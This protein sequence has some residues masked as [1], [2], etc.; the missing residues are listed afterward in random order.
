MLGNYPEV[1]QNYLR[2]KDIL[3]R[4]CGFLIIIAC[5][6]PNMARAVSIENCAIQENNV[7]KEGSE[8]K[9]FEFDPKVFFGNFNNYIKSINEL[10]DKN[11]V[12]DNMTLVLGEE[13]VDKF[14]ESTIDLRYCILNA[15]MT[16]LGGIDVPDDEPAV[17]VAEAD[18]LVDEEVEDLSS[19]P[20]KI[21]SGQSWFTTDDY[22]AAALRE[23]RQGKVKYDLTIGADGKVLGCQASGPP[24][25]S[26]L[27]LAT[28]EAIMTRARFNP[29]TDIGGNPKKGEFSGEVNWT[30]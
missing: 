5:A 26:D 20:T 19:P 22:P 25:S 24:G 2:I 21:G 3:F 27:E 28:C 30:N 15:R 13:P 18:E 29:A 11:V 17:V 9:S 1:R 14:D 12:F 7:I 10:D 4:I 8:D 6:M 23:G 16:E